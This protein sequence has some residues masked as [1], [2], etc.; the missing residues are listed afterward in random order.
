MDISVVIPAY[1]VEKYI[2]K[3]L[4]SIIKQGFKNLEII[5][6]NN[7]STD[8]TM[9]VLKK[10]KDK[11]RVID[12]KEAN[13]GKARNEGVKKSKGKYILFVDSD[14]YLESNAL[15]KIY[16]FAVKND[17]DLVNFDYNTIKNNKKEITKLYSHDITNIYDD[18]KLLYEINYGPIKLFKK[19]IIDKYNISFSV[20]KKYEDVMFVSEFLLYAKKVGKID[21][22]LYNYVVH[23]NSETTVRDKRVFDILDIMKEHYKLYKKHEEL[24]D[25]YISFYVKTL[26]NYTIQQ[27]YQKDKK[28]RKD[29]IN[30]AFKFLNKFKWKKCSYLKTRVWYKKIIETSKLL[31]SLYCLIYTKMWYNG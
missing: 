18:E 8:K 2:K 17:L 30:E 3:C 24:S 15:K 9:D 20:D 26:T 25:K 4:D 23:S 14:D 11:V 27:R 13:L 29:F 10:Y 21:E 28:I 5:V 19:S 16:N 31:T 22:A 12:L 7:G 6:V 1:N